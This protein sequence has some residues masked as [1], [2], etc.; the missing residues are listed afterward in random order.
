MCQEKLYPVGKD[1]KMKH[2]ELL[3]VHDEYIQ[4]NGC[5]LG[6][7]ELLPDK[8]Q[9]IPPFTLADLAFNGIALTLIRKKLLL[10]CSG[11]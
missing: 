4:H 11:I 6:V 1:H 2:Q 10:L 8:I 7:G 5:P 3:E 9:A